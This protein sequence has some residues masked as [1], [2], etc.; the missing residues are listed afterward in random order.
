MV[1][2][3]GSQADKRSN[4]K[5]LT[6]D[7]ELCKVQGTRLRTIQWGDYIIIELSDE[8]SVHETEDGAVG[9]GVLGKLGE[10]VELDLRG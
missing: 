4:R 8:F 5:R 7:S 9:S 3:P 6:C 2:R 10:A 1:I